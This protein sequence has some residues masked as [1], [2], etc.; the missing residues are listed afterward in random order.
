MR[1]LTVLFCLSLALNAFSQS[2]NSTRVDSLNKFKLD[3]IAKA[4]KPLIVIDGIIYTGDIHTIKPDDISRAYLLTTPGATNIYGPRAA[5]GAILITT[6]NY[7]EAYDRKHAK[8]SDP[9][10]DSVLVVIDGNVSDKEK[11]KDI[12]PND[13]LDS[14]ILKS[15]DVDRHQNKSTYTITTKQFAI[16]AYKNKFSTL[17]EEY[18]AYL[19]NHNNDDNGLMYI[20]DGN[21]YLRDN[22]SIEML[23]KILAINISGVSLGKVKD[24][25]VVNIEIKK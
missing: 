23:Y 15:K 2:K 17:C 14:E 8:S 1:L 21:I 22:K 9:I 16:Q 7:Q 4:K 12:N 10:V 20:V 6:R 19:K 18:K 24:I 5:G 3:S 25:E 13:I 11:L